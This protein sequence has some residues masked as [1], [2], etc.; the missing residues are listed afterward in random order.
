MR[1]LILFVALPYA[2]VVALLV[3]PVLR[4]LGT[5]LG[6]APLPRQPGR[7]FWGTW[8]W[9][10]GLGLLL[11]GHLVAF[12][13]PGAIAIWHASRYGT[14]VIEGL[15]VALAEMV[16]V[17]LAASALRRRRTH[18]LAAPPPEAA[19][20]IARSIFDVCFLFTVLLAIAAGLASSLGFRWA[21]VWYADTLLPYVRSLARFEPEA[22]LLAELPFVVRLHAV[23]GFVALGLLPLTRYGLLLARPWH[24]L[25]R[26]GRARREASGRRFGPA[27]KAGLAGLGLLLGAL[28]LLGGQALHSVGS[29]QGYAPVQPIAF[30]HRLHAGDRQIPCL[31]CHFAAERSRH[32]GIP[33]ANVCMNCHGRLR[34][35][36][37]E[38]QKLKEAVAQNRAIRWVKIHNLP[39]F[40]YF[41][42][43]QHVAVARLACQRCHGPIETMDRVR[44]VAP[45]T[46]GWCLDCHR[47]EG[48]VLPA[49]R[50]V[51]LPPDLARTR[52]TGGQDCSKCHY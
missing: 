15:G 31:Y 36:S 51:A 48:V 4:G 7:P 40:V 43:S 49:L 13:F 5:P 9:A 52:A 11:A 47:S 23:A 20:P 18:R 6:L 17:G 22:G 37:A 41:D 16:L 30:S 38:L 3:V 21:S 26:P 33:A 10:A 14:Q 1:E 25:R 44:Q 39:D 42:H 12:A 29:S 35:A 32:A 45:L 46:M 24:R 27:M 34:L 50:K 8:V 2:A 28:A 19:A